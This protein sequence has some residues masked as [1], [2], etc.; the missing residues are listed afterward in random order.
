MKFF[1]S[2]EAV[3]HKCVRDFVVDVHINHVKPHLPSVKIYPVFCERLLIDYFDTFKG[4]PS[5][6]EID[7]RPTTDTYNTA[8]SHYCCLPERYYILY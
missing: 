1:P 2:V 4:F 5:A 6:V 8:S 3:F 7:L